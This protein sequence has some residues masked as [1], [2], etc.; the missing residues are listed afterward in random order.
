MLAIVLGAFTSPFFFQG[1]QFSPMDVLYS[2]YPWKAEAPT[3]YQAPSNH[4]RWDDASKFYP[5]RVNLVRN[6]LRDG[7][8]FWQTDHL[9]GTPNRPTLHRYQLLL[10]PPLWLFFLL[11]FNLANTL[12]HILN[13]YIA[14][15]SM[16][17]LLREHGL[18]PAPAL[19]GA[20]VFM[21]NGFFVVWMSAYSLAA[22]LALLPLALWLFERLVRR[23]GLGYALILALVLTWQFYLG[24]PPGSIVFLFLFGLYGL[25]S[26]IRLWAKARGAGVRQVIGP[27]GLA[28]VLTIGLS[29]FYLLPAL[30]QL[31]GSEYMVSRTL[32]GSHS[33]PW[34]FL[35]GF[36]FPDFWGNPTHVMGDVWV[37]IWNY[38]EV[39]AYWG[40]VALVLAV[41]GLFSS[42]KRGGIYA[43][44]VL[45]LILALSMGYGVWPFSY[46]RY[47]PGI[48]GANPTRWHFGIVLA[49]T[50]L[51]ALGF[52]HLMDLRPSQR[53]MA[54]WIVLGLGLGYGVLLVTVASPGAIQV[55]FADYPRLIRSHYRQ[56]GLLVTTLLLLALFIRLHKKIPAALFSFLMLG[57]VV[58]DLF[59]FGANFNPYI[60][61]QELYPSTPGIRFLQSR[62]ALYRIA[63]W[64]H[65]LGVLP[66]YTANVYGLSTITGLDHYRDLA[67]GAFLEPLMSDSVQ[68][69]AQE[70]GYVRIDQN[71]NRN[72]ALLD[73]LNVRYLVTEPGAPL[74][75]GVVPVY[76]GPDMRVYENPSA[77]PRSWGVFD[78]E[79]ASRDEILDRLHAADFDPRQLVFLETDPGLAA[80]RPRCQP[81]AWESQV[82]GYS[83]DEII[84]QAD[85]GCDGILITSGRYAPGWE[86]T[87]D[88][89]RVEVL[90]ADYLLRA[91]PVPAGQH[92]VHFRYR[93]AA[94]RWGLAISLPALLLFCG[95]LGYVW[96][97]WR[98]TLVLA[99]LVP[100]A[101][102]L[103]FGRP[104]QEPAL[105][106][107]MGAGVAMIDRYPLVPFSQPAHLRDGL[108]EMAF[109]GYDLVGT[110]FQPGDTLQLF[111][112]WQG[113]SKVAGDYTVFTHLLD[114]A[115]RRWAQQDQ[116]PLRGSVPTSTW[117]EGQVIVD[118]YDLTIDPQAP[119]TT[120]FL[121][122]GM[123]DPSTGDRVPLFDIGGN[124]LS[125]D[126]VILETG[127]SIRP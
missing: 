68:A 69:D 57:M 93:P 58:V 127:L 53:I 98:G 108:G 76:S 71:L 80:D 84:I 112:Y 31:A 119:E 24:Y 65:W 63:P 73:M 86:A 96:Q 109:L 123:Y 61:D 43:Y 20:L 116:P 78:Y 14:A 1:K 55:R 124:R 92:E 16:W 26:L 42:R 121:V 35:L 122:I 36:L 113:V 39:I 27:L 75:E 41:F 28:L 59:S 5:S 115:Q 107:A 45:A 17:L 21:L 32:R 40:V 33:I 48:S 7:M 2:Y 4:L 91:V 118:R 13:L 97:G 30:Q 74:L 44:A 23:P 114:D 94:Q 19:A 12:V 111:L 99:G 81:Q 62:D 11:P 67:Y 3:W 25:V 126:L 82:V 38:C 89:E 46:L 51:A 18:K 34:Q 64:G 100:A 125:D 87:V 49:G 117:R 72:R 85:L 9:F 29:A 52:E 6:F 22:M 102:L 120:A 56:I 83:Q 105:P 110:E 8:T 66:A 106:E 70:Y 54:L 90:R 15:V 88:G 95:L 50:L 79:L 104:W 60:A 37:E 101:V 77:L 47:L 10:Y 103:F